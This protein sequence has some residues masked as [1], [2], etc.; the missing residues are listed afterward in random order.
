MSIHDAE[1]RLREL[2]NETPLEPPLLPGLAEGVRVAAR[3]R[4]RRR[5]FANVLC[6]FLAAGLGIAVARVSDG[7]Q[8][9]SSVVTAST[10]CAGTVVTASAGSQ[11][12]VMPGQGTQE[13]TV[14]L[15]GFVRF[16]AV[17]PCS[18][19]I[20]LVSSLDNLVSRSPT[21]PVTTGSMTA[22]AAKLG[23]ET[24][25]VTVRNCPETGGTASCD[26]PMAVG[27]ITVRITSEPT[28]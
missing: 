26:D 13:L 3:R 16:E 18:A 8:S 9:K 1:D 20:E 14:Q 7:R 10:S 4:R 24:A 6:V 25:Q 21:F 17:G 15:G 28:P 11:R 12:V 2:M 23:T 27:M 19:R 22:D 5:Q